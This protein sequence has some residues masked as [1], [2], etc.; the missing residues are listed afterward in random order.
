MLF[1]RRTWKDISNR[2]ELQEPTLISNEYE[3]KIQVR[4]VEPIIRT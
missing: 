1:H 2:Y 4:Q 3:I